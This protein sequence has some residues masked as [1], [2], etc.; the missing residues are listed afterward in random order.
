MSCIV[1]GFNVNYHTT[2]GSYVHEMGIRRGGKMALLAGVGP[3]GLGAID[4]AI[5][6]D[7]R[8]S[9]LVVT[10]I[11]EKRLAR[12]A[13]LFPPEEAA[14]H[15]VEL[16]YL[17]SPDTARLME[18]SGG[19]GYDDIF[20]YAPV[21]PLVEQ[22]DAILGYDGCLNFFAGPSD[23]N[24]S[25]RFNF[26]DVH[27]NAT[28]IS[29]NS[30]G[31]TDDMKES[32]KLMS[33]GRID[34]SAMITHIGGLDAVADTTLNLPSIPGGKK[35]IYTHL[36]MPLTAI[37]DFA[38][39]AGAG[40]NPLFAELHRLTAANKGLWNAECEKYLLKHGKSL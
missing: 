8:P 29:G 12:A 5:H 39:L 22:A 23:S 28:H 27:Y 11:D 26:Y 33:E 18:V 40:K 6:R 34:P 36:S 13:V 7:I 25:A 24:F 17:N 32:L 35:L 31:N 10:D 30:G 19:S 14:R 21:T 1:G 15:G 16:V 9:M 2:A 38:E 4:Y 20:V 3:M 37:S